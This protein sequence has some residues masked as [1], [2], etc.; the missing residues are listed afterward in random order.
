M[1]SHER[2]VFRLLPASFEDLQRRNELRYNVDVD[3]VEQ[4]RT[5]A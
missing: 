2:V 1:E 4:V 3:Q 5:S